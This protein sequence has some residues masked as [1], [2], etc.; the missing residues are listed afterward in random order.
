QIA[1]EDG[2]WE[3]DTVSSTYYNRLRTALS[4]QQPNASAWDQ[5]YTYDTAKRHQTIYS[6]AGTF[7]YIYPGSG[8]VLAKTSPLHIKLA[9]PSG[10]YITNSYDNLARL[11][12]TA[13][14]TSGNVLTNQHGYVYNSG[15]ERTR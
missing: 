10:A 3:D 9:L 6:P 1:T 5:S 13:L 14:K 11:T 2:P 15:N 12:N 7:T 4:L 8:N